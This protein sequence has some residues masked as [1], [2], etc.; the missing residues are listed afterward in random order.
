MYASG[1]SIIKKP[2]SSTM[3]LKVTLR[4][5]Q[6]VAINSRISVLDSYGNE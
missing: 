5:S 6:A 4:S 2:T 1:S 3:V